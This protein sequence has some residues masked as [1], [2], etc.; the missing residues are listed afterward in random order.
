MFTRYNWKIHPFVLSAAVGI[1]VMDG[2]LIKG[3][4]IEIISLKGTVSKLSFQIDL[5]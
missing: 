4:I 3:A 2:K 1:Y 5:L